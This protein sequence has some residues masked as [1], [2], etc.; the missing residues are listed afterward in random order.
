MRYFSFA[1]LP[2]DLS[3]ACFCFTKFLRPLVE[4][5][6]LMSHN[7]FVYLDDEFGSQSDKCSAAAAAATQTLRISS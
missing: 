5:W 4:R 7:S 1:I 2:F 6:R 3:G